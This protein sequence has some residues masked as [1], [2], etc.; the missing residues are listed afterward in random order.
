[1]T[2]IRFIENAARSKFYVLSLR[3]F[4]RNI[5]IKAARFTA[6]FS[7]KNVIDEMTYD[8]DEAL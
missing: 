7:G 5:I 8:S 4:L 2:F 3:P 1:M 6:S